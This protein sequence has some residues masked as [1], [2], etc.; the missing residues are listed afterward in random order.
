MVNLNRATIL[1]VRTTIQTK[2][3]KM[4]YF[5]CNLKWYRK[6]TNNIQAAYLSQIDV[7]NVVHIGQGRYYIFLILEI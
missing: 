2:L 5:W 6:T 7:D 4:N 3:N 1:Y